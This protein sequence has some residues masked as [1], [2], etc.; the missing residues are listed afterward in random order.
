LVGSVTP[1][2]TPAGTS[3]TNQ[4]VTLPGGTVVEGSAVAGESVPSQN[5]TTTLPGGTTVEVRHGFFP[6][7]DGIAPSGSG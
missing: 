6:S 5:A 2:S 1:A 3:G 4:S 7:V